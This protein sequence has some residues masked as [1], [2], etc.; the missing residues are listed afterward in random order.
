MPCDLKNKNKTLFWLLLPWSDGGK[1]TSLPNYLP[2]SPGPSPYWVHTPSPSVPR[3]I[4][5]SFPRVTQLE[6]RPLQP[7]EVPF[8]P[9]FLH[10][11]TKWW[12][13]SEGIVRNHWMTGN[14]FLNSFIEFK[15]KPVGF[16][17]M[18][19]TQWMLCS[20]FASLFYPPIP[21]TVTPLIVVYRSAHF[22]LILGS[23]S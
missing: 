3:T 21:R 5:Q 22:G 6:T 23:V 9:S 19:G 1:W 10:M 17:T 4:L 8:F 12:E 20:S 13:L 11:P 7:T 14:A 16:H 15:R 2:G 18:V